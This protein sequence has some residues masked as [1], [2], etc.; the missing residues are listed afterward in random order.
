MTELVQV[1]VENTVYHFDKLFTYQVPEPFRAHIVPG[2][3]VMVPFGAGNRKRIGMVFA[4]EGDLM[5]KPKQVDSLL[6]K[7][8]VLDQEMLGLAQWLKDRC[9]CTL[10]EAVKLMIPA[11]LQFRVRDSYVLSSGFTDFDRESYDSLSWQII[12]ALRAAGRAVPFEKLSGTLGINRECPEFL[13]LLEKGIVCKVNM[14]ASKMR[15]AFTKMVRPIDGFSGKLSSRQKEVY[16]VLTDVGEASEKE[17][18]YFTGASSS[19]VK[20]LADK[21]AAEIFEYE[22]YRRPETAYVQEGDGKELTLS[23]AQQQILEEL[24]QEYEMSG[25]GSRCA[26]LY[27]VTG[28]GKTSVFLKLME[29]VLAQGQG[30]IVMVPEISLT[31]QTL[32]QFGKIFGDQV[33]VFHSG[34]SLGERMDEWKR[35]RRGEAKIAVGTRSAVFA[36]VRN[37]GLIVIDEEQEH[38]Y[39]SEA[40]PRY[41]AREVARYRCASAKAFCLLSSAT[42]SIETFRLAKEGRF[43]FHKLANRFGTAKIPEVELVDMNWEDIPGKP[44]GETLAQALQDNFAQGK[45]SILLLNRRGYHTF[46]TCRSCRQVVNCPHCSISMTY[47]SANRRLMCHYC[48]YSVSVSKKC[49]S[50]GQET[51]TFRGL[52]TQK[53]EEQLRELLPEAQVLRL[54][55]D[56]VSAKY[57]LE[58]RLEDFARGEYQVMVGT[59]MVAKGLNFENVTLVGVL[60]ADQSLYNDDF[61]SNERTFDLLTQVVGRAGRGKYP[62]RAIIQTFTPENSVLHLAAKQDYFSFVQEELA[63]RKALLYPPYV[64]LLVIGFVGAEE[65]LTRQAAQNF[66]E[67]F[68]GLAEREFANLPLRVLQPSPAAVARVSGKYRYKL[69]IKCRNSPELRK[70]TAQ[71]LT[72][73]AGQREFQQVSVYADPNPNRIL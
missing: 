15:D 23:L 70:M 5:T 6:D 37:L 31:S 35:V 62:G 43:F 8:P 29:Y 10:F 9:Y 61:R 28:S 72:R 32:R 64:D 63:Y 68:S 52:G 25:S 38:T 21:G 48:G 59:Q 24:K 36:P 12:M 27:G 1:A 42:P 7:E 3:R 16:Q 54:D 17:L 20:A 33:A 57:S 2:M 22:V 51:L 11:G 55:T 47:H 30:A 18:C 13:A 45:Q 67:Q 46:I 34:L 53:A 71:L 50:C 41:D 40:S 26:L 49:P 69:I 58:R 60:S 19:V 73:F 39:K 14:A 44:I 56:S 65:A 66:L 4:L